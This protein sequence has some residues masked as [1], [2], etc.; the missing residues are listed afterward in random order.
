MNT[1]RLRIPVLSLVLTVWASALW[2]APALER[3]ILNQGGVAYYELTATPSGGVVELDVPRNQMDD[4]LKSLTV[5]GGGVRIARVTVSGEAP[6]EVA[7]GSLP[8]GPEAFESLPGLL[9]ALRGEQVTVVA[10]RTIEGRIVSV[11]PV[12]GIQADPSVTL[13]S[14]IAMVRVPVSTVRSVSLADKA[15]DGVIGQALDAFQAGRGGGVKRLKITLAGDAGGKVAL[16]YVA[17]APLWKSVY[18]LTLNG[19]KGDLEGWAVL[20][21]FSGHDWVDVDLTL[22]SGNPATFRQALYRAY[23]VDRPEMP[24]ELFEPII[25]PV[26]RGVMKED[27]AVTARMRAVADH[28]SGGVPTQIQDSATQILIDL[29]KVTLENG[30][31]LTQ[32][33]TRGD[34]PVEAVTY[35]PLYDDRPLAAFRIENKGKTS[36]PPGVV[37]V[38]QS[39]G[40][41]RQYLGDSRM[42]VVPVGESRM[43]SYAGDFKVKVNRAETSRSVVSRAHVVEGVMTVIS[44]VYHT[45][46]VDVSLPKS[47]A[48]TMVVDFHANDNWTPVTP[49][50][51]IEKIDN[52]YRVTKRFGPGDRGK[53][54]ARFVEERHRRIT[55]LDTDVSVLVDYQARGAFKGEMKAALDRVVALKREVSAAERALDQASSDLARAREAEDRARE[56]LK[57][58]GDVPLRQQYLEKLVRAEATVNQAAARQAEAQAALQKAEAALRDFVQ[59]LNINT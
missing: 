19:D 3:V 26:D 11:D 27:V 13:R 44:A 6:T 30:K 7:F 10:D 57:A 46:T 16:A 42:G 29:G 45:R 28:A 22:S 2:A 25:P 59:N 15:L 41:D 47:E 14:G 4:V 17:G 31:T 55:L 38:Y 49:K 56:N 53:I 20:E 32:P 8:L 12:D 39:S 21:N 24:V 54:E 34:A 51:G 43:L 23:F 1:A 18:R 52:G 9:R 58:V 33:I 48:R 5:S 50:S 37:T 35:L 40:N 36:L